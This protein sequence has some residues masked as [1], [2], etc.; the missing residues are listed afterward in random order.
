MRTFDRFDRKTSTVLSSGVAPE[1]EADE[2][3]FFGSR[4][5]TLGLIHLEAQPPFQCSPLRFDPAGG[6]AFGH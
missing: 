5:R 2:V 1:A 6:R 3:P 4:Y